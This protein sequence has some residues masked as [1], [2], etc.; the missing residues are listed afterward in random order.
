MHVA[1]ANDL[2]ADTAAAECISMPPAQPREAGEAWPCMTR[3]EHERLLR[4]ALAAARTRLLLIGAGVGFVMAV[5]T[6]IGGCSV[7]AALERAEAPPA[8]ALPQMVAPD[9]RGS[10]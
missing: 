4:A 8:G 9:P 6:I 7:I 2:L 3:A 1:A 5:A 10:V